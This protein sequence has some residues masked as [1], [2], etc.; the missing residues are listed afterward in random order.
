V[1]S[2]DI[3]P[4]PLER[5]IP[6][7]WR[8]LTALHS[9]RALV[10][11]EGRSDTFE[12]IE[13]RSAALARGLLAEGAGKGVRIGLL[14][15]NSADWIVSFLAITRIG[16]I[17]VTLSTFL[18]A[19]ELRYAIQ[20]A[21][22]A[23]LLSADRYLRHD[24]L[25]RLEEALP[26]LT[27]A[28]GQAPLALTACPYLRGVWLVG[29]AAAPTW[30]RGRLGDLEDEGVAS[31]TFSEAL[32]AAVERLVSPADRAMLIYTSGS[33][34]EPKG[35][36]HTHGTIVDKVAFMVR[37]RWLTPWD[38]TPDDRPIITSPFFWIGGFLVLA[39]T[40]TVGATV[41]CVDEHAPEAL[42]DVIRREGAT[43]VSGQVP[44]LRALAGS[45]QCEPGDLER[46]KPQNSVQRP[47][48]NK[49]PAIA[50]SQF[51]NS[52]GMTE[53][54][55]P[56]SGQVTGE[57]LPHRL[58]NS[59]GLAL[60]GMELKIVDPVTRA[61]LA[62]GDEG[63]LFVRGPWLMDGFYKRERRE[64][65][66]PDGF[67]ATGDKGVID[68]DGHLFYRGRLGGMIKTAGANVAPEEVEAAIRVH[69]AVV[70]V[71]VIGLPDE[72][73]GEMVVAVV[74][75]KPGRRIDEHELKARLRHQLSSFK[76]PK[77]F[78]FIDLDELPLTPS[79]KI[80]K[81]ALTQLITKLLATAKNT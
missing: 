17:A 5:T 29:T 50:P 64:V 77:R 44:S 81:P 8:G 70:D 12:E 42:I 39:C 52:L 72:E 20:H 22:V 75:P 79:N 80:R 66:Q 37:A 46:L 53:T 28:D 31:E 26:G 63:E 35:V 55:G 38:I 9:E 47:F 23:I 18:A 43:Q 67:Y 62:A 19:E 74:A 10:R 11:H 7:W 33:T 32:L 58:A 40:M 73:L 69:D 14:M 34:S 27:G 1:R 68:A 2:S 49:D 6:G 36:L 41:L 45:P 21:D 71:A 54:F 13:R 56:H 48:F 65:F 57:V 59:F 61:P 15:P 78:L 60:G 30:V 76:V 3:R 25:G 51:C 4:E 24:Y 16:G